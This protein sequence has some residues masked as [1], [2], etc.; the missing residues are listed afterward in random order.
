MWVG[1][2]VKHFLYTYST[3]SSSLSTSDP[4]LLFLFHSFFSLFRPPSFSSFS[5]PDG[6]EEE[7]KEYIQP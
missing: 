7:E 5:L 6:N 4:S 1:G 2:V 3:S